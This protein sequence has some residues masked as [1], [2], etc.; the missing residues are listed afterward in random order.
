MN[1][2][3]TPGPSSVNRP[4]IAA[5]AG[6]ATSSGLNVRCP[7]APAIVTRS[8]SNVNV[9]APSLDSSQ[10]TAAATREAADGN[11]PGRSHS[12]PPPAGQGDRAT[13]EVP[14]S[15]LG[16]KEVG[17]K[18]TVLPRF[19]SKLFGNKSRSFSS[20]YY[21]HTWVEY[22]VRK[23][24]VFCFAC[25]HFH[26]GSVVEDSFIVKGVSDWK[27]IGGKIIK[28]ES[29]G[30]HDDCMV[31]WANFE[32]TK[33]TGS[34]VVNLS[35]SHKEQVE[36]NRAYLHKVVDVIKLLSTLGLPLRGHREG[37]DEESRGNF[38]EV[39]GFFSKYDAAFE[40]MQK[41]YF[42]CTSHDVQDEVI[43]I[44][45]K[46]VSGEIAEEIRSTGF[47]TIIADE[48]KSSKSE[49]LSVCVRYADKLEIKER[50][51][52]FIDCSATRDAAGILD[53]I[54]QGLEASGL[55]N[56]PIVAQCYDGASVMSGHV[57]GV[58]QRM[59]E[60]HPHAMYIHCLA[61]K[62]N[63]V[64]V[65]SCT[66]NRTVKGFLTVLDKL[67]QV[68]AEPSNHHRFVAMQKALA[69]KQIEIVQPSDTRWAYKWRCVNAVKTRYSAI[70][71][72]L[73]EMRDEGEKWAVEASG[74]YEQMTRLPF[75]TCLHVLE[76]VLRVVHV[77][78]KA[79]QSTECTLAGAAGVTNNLKAH[80]TSMREQDA[81][82]SVWA[83]VSEF[84]KDNNIS[85]PKDTTAEA[86]GP[87]APKR[88]RLSKTPSSLANST[89]FSTLGQREC[90]TSAG[91]AAQPKTQQFKQH[92]YF[93]VLDTMISE[94]ERRFGGEVMEVAEACAAVLDC[95]KDGI[96]PLLQKYAELLKIHPQLVK[97]EMDLIKH[98]TPKISLKIL[99]E[100]V[101]KRAYPNFYTVLQLALTLPIGSVTSER[102]FSAM[103]RIR[104]WQRS[105]MGQSR[106]SSLAILH[107]EADLT[108][109]L[110][111]EKVVNI[112]AGRKKRRI[113]LH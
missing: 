91:S 20:Y 53:G 98:S 108:K 43:G 56:I 86:P 23:D 110:S 60:E 29:S 70:T 48:A 67:Y 59:K 35:D 97:S 51:L 14:E 55:T 28:H 52:C 37:K 62:L 24:A 66:V 72:C 75:V 79:L 22:S 45:A 77:T 87:L 104:N 4:V 90:E 21:K 84:C 78:H 111:P 41:T 106:F 38:H 15:D 105:T 33:S 12:S 27:K 92:L 93:P 16:E 36:R 26:S 49:Q 95:N 82:T 65:E 76:D 42:N 102:S 44:C 94:L 2:N 64:L 25:R 103:R 112:Y 113:Q 69:L 11:V 61:H 96:D 32:Q 63:L 50:F 74:L 13:N 10:G 5:G 85:V 40:T 6:E 107:I 1:D 80:L 68:F 9:T 34:V 83:S 57:T 19:P 81:W 8:E 39:C 100:K 101:K 7:T 88:K 17:P 47:F 71:A 89:I 30:P 3:A 18:Q 46:L 99:R 109:G 31:R 54:K 73:K 58:Q